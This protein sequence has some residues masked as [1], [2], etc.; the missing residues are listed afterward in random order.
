MGN[1][2]GPAVGGSAYGG[3]IQN[4]ER[5]IKN[6]VFAAGCL[7][8]GCLWLNLLAG[9]EA[10]KIVNEKPAIPVKVMEVELKTIND[11][12][13]Y[14]GDVRAQEE[15]LVYP[16]VSGK[17]IEKIKDEGEAVRK[18]EAIFYVDRDQIGFKF[19]KS[20]VEV[21]LK[22]VIGR[23]YV[24]IGTSVTPQTPVALVVDMD[25]VKIEL[26][27][28][29][30]YLAKVSLGQKA[31]ISVQAYPQ[32]EFIGEVSKISPV[33]DLSTRTAPIEIL[34]SNKDHRLRSGMF[35][36]VELII[37]EHNN[38]PVIIKEAVMGKDPDNY[39]YV[40]DKNIVSQRRVRLGIRSG[41]YYEVVEGLKKGD[42]VVV[43][44]QQ[45]LFD[46]AKVEVEN[47]K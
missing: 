34:V 6:H 47:G 39:V 12:L 31:R 33:L 27:V 32:E 13:N 37:E 16:K 18:Q 22:G 23:V 2:K 45:K 35:V 28:P 19:E 41:A 29:E 46:G 25:K 7:I 5:E 26:D 44:G 20:P 11:T 10:E 42:V 30:V 3:K 9:C 43:V 4:R 36:K 38:V 21:P 15:V 17:V 8:L 24:D 1:S 40:A 14:V